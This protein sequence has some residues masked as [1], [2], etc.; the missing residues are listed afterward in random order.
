MNLSKFELQHVIAFLA[1][2]MGLLSLRR[3]RWLG[4]R[5]GR[6]AF[7]LDS[8]HRGIALKNL[9]RAR[10][11]NSPVAN[12]ELAR[13]VFENLGKVFFEIAWA[14]RLCRRDLLKYI[15]VEGLNH[16]QNAYRKGR[17]VMFLTAHFGNWE[18]LSVFPA[19]IDCPT[20]IVYRP[21]DFRP[22]D[23]FFIDLRSRFG[24]RL[25]PT[26]RSAARIL[27]NLRNGESVGL[28]MDQNV[29]WYEG[30]F[31]DFLGQRACTNKIMAIL[32]L[33]TEA[34]VVPIF[35]VRKESGFEVTILPEIEL[36]KSNDKIR[37]IE[38]NTE[39]YNKAI[40]TIVRRHPDQWFWVHQ[41]WKTKAFHPW[42]RE[43]GGAGR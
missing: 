18:L 11:V 28:L 36:I 31:V 1:K 37:D 33:K 23:R 7:Y 26:K 14:S 29:D 15:R 4:S 32:A 17:G 3:G 41:R 43:E 16:F 40:E 38:T 5:L 27:K 24:G 25:I 9:A 35:M 2:M 6:L 20:N 30:V 39:Q 8:R 21:L 10:D 12:R 19:M 34:P 13:Q 42:P 22:L